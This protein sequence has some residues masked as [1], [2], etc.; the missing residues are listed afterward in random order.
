MVWYMFTLLG[1][2]WSRWWPWEWWAEV[3]I[4]RRPGTSWTASS[5]S[6]GLW[7]IWWMWRSLTCQPSE[8]SGSSDLS[9]PSTEY[10]AWG[11]AFNCDCFIVALQDSCNAFTW[12]FAHVGQCSAPL[13]LCLLHL[14]HCWCSTVGWS[15][16]AKMLCQWQIYDRVD[17]QARLWRVRK[18]F[19]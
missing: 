12:H 6:Q 2:C 8:L 16:E 5:S 18:D 4:Y 3:V 19:N 15:P 9:R 14:W 17:N 1:K 7:S 10:Q 13:L 11:I